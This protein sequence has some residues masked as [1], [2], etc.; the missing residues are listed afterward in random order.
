MLEVRLSYGENYIDMDCLVDSGS[1]DSL[2]HTDVADELGISL[3]GLETRKYLPVGGQ[4]ITGR[5]ATIDL[6]VKGLTEVIEIE[7]AF[8]E[9]NQIPVLG[10]SGFFENYEIRFQ[11]SKGFFEIF[12]LS[13]SGGK[14]L[15]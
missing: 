8:V 1:I 3:A 7:V 15:M 14:Y 13:E 2:F 9:A 4:Q 11:G 12:P 6:Q 10:Q 5:I